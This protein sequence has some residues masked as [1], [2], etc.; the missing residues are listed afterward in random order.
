MNQI[1][2]VARTILEQIQINRLSAMIGVSAV[3]HD[4]TSI[5]VRFRAKALNGINLF[6]ITLDPDDTYT[7]A[8]YRV[9]V[10]G[11]SLKYETSDVYCDQLIDLL[12]KRTGLAFRMPQIYNAS[13]GRRIA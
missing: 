4:K 8:L 10:K 9:T 5:Q 6:K 1:G 7:V 12:E 3:L 13:T 11:A 2:E